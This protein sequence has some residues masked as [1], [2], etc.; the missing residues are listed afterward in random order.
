MDLDPVCPTRC[1]LWA[2]CCVVLGHTAVGSALMSWAGQ[3][4]EGMDKSSGG[5]FTADLLVAAFASQDE[6]RV[7]DGRGLSGT[8]PDYIPRVDTV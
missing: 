5:W 3:G 6:P 4:D 2:G 7:W 8:A 1:A